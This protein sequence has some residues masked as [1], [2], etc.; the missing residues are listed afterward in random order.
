MNF[1]TRSQAALALSHIAGID[2]HIAA[3]SI[4]DG[5]DDNGIDAIYFDEVIRTVYVV[6]SKWMESG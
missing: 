4:V 3:T 6:Q 2:K 1:L 5:F